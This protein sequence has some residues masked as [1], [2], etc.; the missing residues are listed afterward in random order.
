M[1]EVRSK[2]LM[3]RFESVSRVPNSLARPLLFT[4]TFMDSDVPRSGTLR[5]KCVNLFHVA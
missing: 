4:H 2:A 3:L 5:Q 1:G